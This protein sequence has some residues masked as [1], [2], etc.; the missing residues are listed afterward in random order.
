MTPWSAEPE[1][2]A[3]E[4]DDALEEEDLAGDDAF[5]DVPETHLGDEA[6]E[7]FVSSELD[8]EGRVRGDPPVTM[9]IVLLSFLVLA[10][11]LLIF[12]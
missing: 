7:E 10:V 5:D 3:E 9:V 8:S 4:D 12:G 6:Y 1:E 2:G 11:A